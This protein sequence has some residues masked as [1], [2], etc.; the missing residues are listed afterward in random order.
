MKH[1]AI[2]TLLGAELQS[3]NDGVFLNEQQLDKIN[4]A[5]LQGIADASALTV[6]NTAVA[7]A[8]KAQ[9]KTAD[10]LV[11]ANSTIAV[12]VTEIEELKT[13]PGAETATV[14]TTTDKVVTNDKDGNV[15]KDNDEFV[16]N[17]RAIAEEFL[18]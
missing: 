10:D 1:E 16:P 4:A 8:K 15:V 5:I 12:Q 6:A 14:V 7:D 2:N 18:S 17:M 9:Q 11:T 3:T 13:K